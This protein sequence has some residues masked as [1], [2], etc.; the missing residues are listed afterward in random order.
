MTKLQVLHLEGLQHEATSRGHSIIVDEPKE[1]GG[2]DQGLSP[3]ELLL[4]ALGACT[5]MTV[6]MYARRKKWPLDDVT[7]ELSHDRVHAKDCQECETEEGQLG[8]IRREVRLVGELSEEQ[9]ARLHEI[10]S[11]CPVHRTLEG[12]IEILETAAE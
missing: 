2:L 8:L 10:A 9:R 5:A 7:V 4:A 12:P 1:L 3:Y 6:R 11:R